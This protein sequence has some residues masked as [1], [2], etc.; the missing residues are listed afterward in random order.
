[1]GELLKRTYHTG[2]LASRCRKIPLS[3]NANGLKINAVDESSRA[4]GARWGGIQAYW[5]NEADQLAGS[6]PK[7]RTMDLS[8]KKLTG[9]CYVTDELLQDAAA[10]ESVLMQGLAEEFGFKVDDAI[11]NGNGAG[12][13]LGILNS[14]SLIVVSKESGQTAGTIV[15][16]NIVKMWSRCWGRSRQ[17]AVWFINQEI[18]PQLYTLRLM[19][20]DNGVPV[21]MPANGLAD[22]P[23]STLFGRPVI[24]LEQCSAMYK[25]YHIVNAL[26]PAANAFAG[27]VATEVINLKNWEHVSFIIHCGA[28]AVG[29]S[30]ITVEACDDTVPTNTEA[31]P[32]TYQEC[33]A[34]DTFSEA[35]QADES[36]FT[37]AAADNKVYKI[38]VDAQALAKTGYSYVRLKAVEVTVD[39]VAGGVIAILTGGRYAQDVL[40]SALV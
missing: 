29:T 12:Q 24:P 8:L 28:G 22:K 25:P 40:D 3:T 20:G 36:G 19:T 4:N 27:T 38:E 32:F 18:E 2:V 16:E 17:N 21:Y 39:P 35:K 34:D 33:I 37:T 31:I 23:Y 5:E 15:V 7:F 30:A 13:P 1:V 10:L 26:P 14:D 9:L 11:L 6:K